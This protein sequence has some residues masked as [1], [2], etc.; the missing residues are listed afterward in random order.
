M[1]YFRNSKSI[2]NVFTKVMNQLSSGVFLIDVYTVCFTAPEPCESIFYIVLIKTNLKNPTVSS[3]VYLLLHLDTQNLLNSLWYRRKLKL[4]KIS[5][6]RSK[7][8]WCS[9]TKTLEGLT[10]THQ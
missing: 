7:Y 8:K 5:L 4:R 2:M 1:W 6:Q 10:S 3:K 9:K